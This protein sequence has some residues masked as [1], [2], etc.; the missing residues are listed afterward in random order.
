MPS[1]APTAPDSAPLCRVSLPST[2][3]CKGLGQLPHSQ[4]LSASSQMPWP[5]APVSL[6]C[7]G[8][9]QG[10][11]SQGLQQIWG[12]CKMVSRFRTVTSFLVSLPAFLA[13][14]SLGAFKGFSQPFFPWFPSTLFKHPLLPAPNSNN[15]SRLSAL[16]SLSWHNCILRTS[17]P[18]AKCLSLLCFPYSHPT[19]T[20][21]SASAVSFFFFFVF[22]F[23]TLFLEIQEAR[24]TGGHRVK[25]FSTAKNS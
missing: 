18:N 11:L 8:N 9:V 21:L 7:P 25:Q 19:P 23:C 16:L 22:S 4:R 5:S 17:S 24:N 2:A 6:C 14:S 1:G 20:L 13:V 12:Q 10:P 15:C 3:A